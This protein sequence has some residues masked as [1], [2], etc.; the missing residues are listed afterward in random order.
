MWRTRS[1]TGR[2]G[3]SRRARTRG[4]R[5]R[6]CSPAAR[7]ERAASASI[8]AATGR[9]SRC[10]PRTTRSSVRPDGSP[11]CAAR[12]R[13]SARASGPRRRWKRRR[14]LLAVTLRSIGD[15]VIATDVEG[16]VVL[17]NR[18]AEQLTGWSHEQALG[19]PLGEVFQIV[20]P[21]TRERC[22]SPVEK[23][24]RSGT[25]VALANH[26]ALV[27]RSGVERIIADSGAPIRDA[28]GHVLGVVLVFRDVTD[29]ERL[30]QELARAQKLESISTLA[31]GI[32]HDFNNL[33]TGV[34]GYL[35]LAER[36][37]PER[38]KTTRS[39]RAAEKA[40][41]RARDLTQQLLTFSRGGAP[42]RQPAHLAEL[43]GES[44]AFALRGSSVVAELALS[45]DLWAAEIDAGQ[46]NQAIS[47][48]AINAVQAMPAGGR[49]RV[50][51]ENVFI[52]D[53]R[54]VEL[55]AGRYVQ[56]SLSDTG[57]GIAPDVLDH[58]FDPYFTT[59]QQGSGLGL[60]TTYSIVKNHDGQITVDSVVGEGATFT[61]YLPATVHVVS[62]AP[63]A[64]AAPPSSGG[65]VLV[66]DDDDVV[67]GLLARMLSEEGY[68]AE[69][70]SDGVEALDRYRAARAAGQ[71]FDVVIMDL[72]VPGGMGGKEAT[73]RL[74]Q[75]DPEARVI[76][77]SGYSNDPI[78]ANYRDHGFSGVLSKPYRVAEVSAAIRE[79]IAR[80]KGA[81]SP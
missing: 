9:G 66:M 68:S 39:L 55:P 75:E 42:V 43:I 80:S 63:P 37:L 38:D 12:S 49:L 59:K 35:S 77:S 47:N 40:T 30:D 15:A 81:L 32:A 48:V 56:L 7:R 5:S 33:L 61:I 27:S 26:T 21:R 72:T 45:P 4:R 18:V 69:R 58:I 29:K 64:A 46:I 57:V 65:R 28:R 11:A 51:A 70:A 67:R 76:V 79:V 13:T 6:T 16:R 19:R 2:R 23:V 53:H 62:A 73:A 34:L 20:N 31:G 17:F 41:L 50:S 71:P 3:T 44:V 24:L 1:S 8:A 10:W 25:A 78:M 52:D 36:S 22:E 54:F 74:L 14:T 60:A